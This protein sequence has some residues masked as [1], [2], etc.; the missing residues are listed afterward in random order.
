MSDYKEVVNQ[1][2]LRRKT[3]EKENRLLLL[4]NGAEEMCLR[5]TQLMSSCPENLVLSGSSRRYESVMHAIVV[6][7]A[8][9]DVSVFDT[10][11]C[12][13]I[14]RSSDEEFL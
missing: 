9:S 10:V 5:Q 7:V 13:Q 11:D 6:S 2:R 4:E 3:K 1:A 12:H 8:E 14:Q